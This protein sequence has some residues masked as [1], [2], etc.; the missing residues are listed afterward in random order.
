MFNNN[1]AKVVCKVTGKDENTVNGIQI[2]WQINGR[3][4]DH[5]IETTESGSSKISTMTRDPTEWKSV[6]KVRCSAIK[7]NVTTVI[8]DL[9][10]NTGGMLLSE[11]D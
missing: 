1:Q 6:K 9:T 10:V 7:D 3:V 2:S 5:K 8:Q 4:T 11:G